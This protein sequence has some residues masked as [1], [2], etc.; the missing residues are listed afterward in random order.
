MQLKSWQIVIYKYI[1]YQTDKIILWI[2]QILE[3]IIE[4]YNRNNY[5][6]NFLTR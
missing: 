2:A 5:L 6:N 1:I 3:K 4:Y